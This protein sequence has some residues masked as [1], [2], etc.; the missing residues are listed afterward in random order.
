MNDKSFFASQRYPGSIPGG[1][2]ENRDS[3]HRPMI[4]LGYFAH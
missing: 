2:R 3:G 1:Q 4:Y